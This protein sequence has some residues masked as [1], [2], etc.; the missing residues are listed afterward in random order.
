MYS[1]STCNG[2]ATQPATKPTSATSSTPKS[3]VTAPK[4]TTPTPT[5]PTV[6][7]KNCTEVKNAGKAPIY[8]GQPG[9][10]SHLDRDGDGIGCE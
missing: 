7:Y 10:A 6:S 1:P 9:Y 3:T 8:K 4:S 5:N 2:D